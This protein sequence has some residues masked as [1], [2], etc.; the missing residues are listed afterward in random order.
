[1]KFILFTVLFG[2]IPLHTSA[3]SID[4]L[5][6]NKEQ[7]SRE[8]KEAEAQ[9][10]LFWANSQG[11]APDAFKSKSK[12]A[13]KQTL[14]KFAV[15]GG[16]CDLNF[17]VVFKRE[18]ETS[19]LTKNESDYNQFLIYL[20]ASNLI[21][22]I[23]YKIIKDSTKIVRIIERTTG[24]YSSAPM[25][26]YTRKNEDVD[27]EKLY[28]SFKAAPNETESCTLGELQR[29]Y[30]SLNAKNKGDRD[31]QMKR[32]NF[33]AYY[34]EMISLETF[35][36]LEILRDEKA[37]EWPINMITY[38]NTILK[39]KDKMA[40]VIETEATNKFT[41]TYASRRL[42]LTQRDRLYALYSPTQMILL[43]EIIQ[44]T[45]KRLD[46]RRVDLNFQLTDD[47]EGERDIYVLSPMEKYRISIN[48][49]KKEMAEAMRSE[50]F[51]G[52][53]IEYEDLVS[54]AYETGYIKSDELDPIIKFEEIWNPKEKKWK[55]YANFAFSLVG[56][57]S[58]Y[59]PPPWNIIGAIGLVV[60][61]SKTI[62]KKKEADPDD[63]WNS[64]I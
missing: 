31:R 55:T 2:L 21:D 25:N 12:E 59:L 58:F 41:T 18:L 34:E 64:I 49:L 19:G 53:P 17:P 29:I 60:L 14:N 45:A 1:M 26:L 28:Q 27:I 56:T 23:F 40:T 48:M 36:K 63:S 30:R 9:A 37:L 7:I 8:V 57:A 62:N 52:I 39:A 32:L 42:K 22:D 13:L 11:L 4:T 20:R 43:A 5:A 6:N 24:Q 3:Q 50:N 38:L 16:F 15:G 51:A 61:Q 10:A 54:A 44:R 46:A 33:I 47:P 35:N